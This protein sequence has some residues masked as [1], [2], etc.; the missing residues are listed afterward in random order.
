[1]PESLRVA[2]P[3]ACGAHRPIPNSDTGGELVGGSG[4]ELE[5]GKA[6][7]ARSRD[8]GAGEPLRDPD[9]IDR[10]GGDH[11]LQVRLGQAEVAAS[12]QAAAADG[13]G[14][15]ALDPSPCG[16]ARSKHLCPL[17]P[18]RF[19]QRLELLARLQADDVQKSRLNLTVGVS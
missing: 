9:E 13:L 6:R 8:Q 2:F 14:M 5:R 3:A 15:R 1:M 11:V 4:C 16:V 10:D 18:A 12:A 7:A 19:L 17:V